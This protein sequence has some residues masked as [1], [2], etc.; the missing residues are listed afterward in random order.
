[1]AETAL[2]TYKNHVRL[3]PLFHYFLLPVAAG[4]V[5]YEIYHLI[6]AIING[7]FHFNLA[8]NVVFALAFA[9][10][11]LKLRLYALK[12]QDRVIRLEQRLRLATLAD[13]QLRP[14]IG[15]L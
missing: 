14:R 4:N 7:G 11:A 3:D 9:V 10:A 12:A 1:M 8:W 5:V 13:E 6:R 2:Q 15:D